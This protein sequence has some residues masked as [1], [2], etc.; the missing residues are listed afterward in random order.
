MIQDA[1][2]V[3]IKE[4]HEYV[5]HVFTSFINWFT[6]FLGWNYLALGWFA[7]SAG[8][9]SSSKFPLFQFPPYS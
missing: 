5:R 9:L 8:G 7:A 1:L 4:R 3:A 6:I 2:Q